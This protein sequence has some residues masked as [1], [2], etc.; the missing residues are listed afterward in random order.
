MKNTMR[1]MEESVRGDKIKRTGPYG[2]A[3]TSKAVKTALYDIAPYA[4]V[5]KSIA[6]RSYKGQQEKKETSS[7]IR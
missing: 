1:M 5:R 2:E 6:N 3:G 7:L 4:S